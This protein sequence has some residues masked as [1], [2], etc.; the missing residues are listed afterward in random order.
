[1]AKIKKLDDL[2]E[3]LKENFERDQIL[4]TYTNLLEIAVLSELD[5]DEKVDDF[6]K[7]ASKL[8]LSRDEV[9]NILR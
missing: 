4:M 3:E 9:I 5:S 6:V 2:V 1:M 8:N 7:T